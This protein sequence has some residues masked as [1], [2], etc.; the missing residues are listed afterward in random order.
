[1]AYAGRVT[2]EW[3]AIGIDLGG[4]KIE[5]AV[6]RGNGDAITI[7]SR[8]R[9]PTE[10]AEG[11]DAIVARTV[12]VVRGA[13]DE[14]GL[15]LASAPIGVGMPGNVTRRGGLVKNSNTVC[16]NGR[17]FREDVGR[18][19][20]RPVAFENDATCF[21][22]AE[23]LHGAGRERAGGIVFGVIMGTGVGGGVVVHGQPWS[24]LQGI[25]GEWGHHGV[26]AGRPDARSCYCGQTGCLEAYASGP[27]VEGTY[28]ALGGP[29]AT[30]PEIAERRGSDERAGEA[31]ESLVDAFGRGLANVI[32]VLDPSVIVLGGGVSNLPF[33]YDEG[34]DRVARYV[35]NDELV[36]P[37]VENELGDSAGVVGAALL[38]RA[39]VRR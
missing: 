28:R 12:E 13:V 24:G 26:Y 31:I 37:I 25:A 39:P 18:A 8:H 4:T 20:G 16:L 27:A 38:G 29:A 5:A 2:A 34:R 10:Q 32:D 19:L 3:L 23:A 30:L 7:E 11:Y 35:F 17:P 6:L 1:M 14:A 33:L 22:L 21:A 15:D 36:T 9:V